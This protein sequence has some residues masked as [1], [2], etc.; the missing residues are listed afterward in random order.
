MDI[1]AYYESLKSVKLCD[2]SILSASTC[3][4]C[5]VLCGVKLQAENV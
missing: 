1:L 2:C 5:K 3:N 4:D